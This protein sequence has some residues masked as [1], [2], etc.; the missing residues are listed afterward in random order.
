M[1]KGNCLNCGKYYEGEGKKFCSYPCSVVY[2]REHRVYKR[3][4]TICL[5]CKKTFFFKHKEVK[6]KFC[7]N[8]CRRK[9]QGT[10]GTSSRFYPKNGKESK[11]Y[12]KYAN[13]TRRAKERGWG[14][15]TSREFVEW[16][17]NQMQKCVYCGIPT[18]TWV[19]VYKNSQWKFGMTI[20]RKNN[21]LGYIKDNL[22]LA[23]GYCN[24]IKNNIL[25][26]EEMIEIGEKYM[27]PKWQNKLREKV[28][29]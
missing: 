17:P 27:K 23:C 24:V 5:N 7:S 19:E 6:R 22:V 4:E 25:T 2:A 1:N 15:M 21:D 20:D 28:N 16:Y 12:S 8:D 3:K 10:Y 26:Y 13:M 14:C 29:V 18:E 9:H 11:L